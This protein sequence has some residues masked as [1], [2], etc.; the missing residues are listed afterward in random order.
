M[1]KRIEVYR[2]ETLPVL[3]FY[4]ESG[5]LAEVDGVDTVENVYNR[6]LTEI[7]RVSKTKDR[8]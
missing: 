7:Q 1:R 6:V 4:R 2:N 3:D 5:Q 8:E